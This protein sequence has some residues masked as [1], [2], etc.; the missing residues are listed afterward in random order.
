V[1]PFYPTL[2]QIT[3]TL[4]AILAAS[5]AAYFVFLQEH[6]ARYEDKIEE[7]KIAIR[8]TVL[9]LR[10]RWPWTISMY[11][12]PEFKDSYRSK[13]PGKSGSEL[14]N[15]AAT[16]FVF[17]GAP[18]QEALEEVQGK[19]S[20]SGPLKGRIYFWILTETIPVVTGGSADTRT[21]PDDVFP[22]SAI[23]PGFERWRRDFDH[24]APVISLLSDFKDQMVS[25]FRV[26]ADGLPAHA[27]TASLAP[28]VSQA[29][30]R[31][32]R[33]TEIVRVKLANIDKQILMKQ[34]YSFSK[35]VGIFWLLMLSGL[36]FLLGVVLPLALLAWKVETN[37][38][39][40][41]AILVSVLILT[42]GAFV[43]FGWDIS[44]PLK[45][46]PREYI[47]ARWYFPLLKEL[48][49]HNKKLQ[50]G[51]LLDRDM[52]ADAANSADKQQFSKEV[53]DALTEYVAGAESYNGKALR[54]NKKVIEVIQSDAILG[55]VVAGYR[56]HRG[57][58]LLYPPDVLDKTRLDEIAGAFT[59]NPDVDISVEVDM[60]RWHRVALKIPGHAFAAEPSQL[61]VTLGSIRQAVVETQEAKEF[62]DARHEL[63]V[64]ASRLR[65]AIESSR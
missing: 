39:A 11:L 19:H 44:A 37:G 21:K 65:V 34:R 20:F 10:A 4:L 30:E 36:A 46:D 6:A 53:F 28:M 48:E 17:D 18:M 58:P 16:D 29:V 33:Q 50:H 7:E 23:G 14:V 1:S 51:G 54:L 22:S 8:E 35:R 31:L 2:A 56:S 43:R 38:I 15:Q 3:A 59:A 25:D 9:E 63:A 47:A 52:F 60:P 49:I 62:M 5:A 61:R 40:G 55:P 12:A 41:S 45:A 24:L 27:R 42:L 13:Y 26:F 32:F 57:G 64:A